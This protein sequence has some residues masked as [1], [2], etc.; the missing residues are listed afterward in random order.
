MG[1]TTRE[2]EDGVI[3]TPA[4]APTSLPRFVWGLHPDSTHQHGLSI[5]ITLPLFPNHTA[6][7]TVI[8]ADAAPQL[9]T[10]TC[11]IPCR[12]DVHAAGRTPPS[13]LLRS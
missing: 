5:V 4:T 10:P 3:M 1:G 9:Q 8:C 6:R 12:T 2:F 7:T 11:E 13:S